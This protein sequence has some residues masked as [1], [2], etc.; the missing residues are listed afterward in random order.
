MKLKLFNTVAQQDELHLL[1]DK[2]HANTEFVRV[3]RKALINLLM[4]HGQLVGKVGLD[5]IEVPNG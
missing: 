3:P 2:C 1:H 4:D 5:N